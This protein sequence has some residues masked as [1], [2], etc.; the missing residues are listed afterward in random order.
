MSMP[1]HQL[2]SNTTLAEL[3]EGLANAPDIA[4]TGIASDTRDLDSGYLFLACGG[5]NSHGL[6]YAAQAIEAGAIAIAYDSRT[7]NAVPA[8]DV[9]LFAV[10]GLRERLGDIANRF[11]DHPSRTVWVIGVTGTNGKTTVAW[12]L[13]QCLQRLG[14]PSGYAGTLGYGMSDVELNIAEGMTTPDVIEM[15]RRLAA[16]RDAGAKFAVAEVSSHALTQDRIKGVCIDTALF[17][18][19]SRD[20]LDYHGDMQAYAEAKAK[21]FVDAGPTR[22]IVNIDTDFG[23]ELATRCGPDAIA[24]STNLDRAVNGRPHVFVR[25]VVAKQGGSEVTV[26][27]SWGNGTVRVPLP[28][29]FNVA[30]AVMALAFLLTEGIPFDEAGAVV[31]KAE[32]PPGRMQR[33]AVGSGPEVYVDYAHTPNALEVA[34]RALR[35]HARGKLWCVF[36]CGG[37]RDSGKRPLMARVVERL[38]DRIV[39]TTDNPR[40][41]DA[42]DIINAIAGGFSNS[43]RATIIEDRAA[44]IA[45]A[46]SNAAPADV[47]L[48]AG[49]GHENYQF[50]GTRRRDF[51]DYEIAAANLLA[52]PHGEEDDT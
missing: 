26:R 17:T 5:V 31:S 27:S 46:V 25:S 6:D 18:N 24:V 3:L 20:H 40:N 2:T 23:A 35:P 29:D 48:L 42:G 49:K 39:V 36:G 19:L 33:V 22:R 7:A 45:W 43:E 32:A 34:L 13:A 4:I 51:S 14:R 41:E 9:P 28:G 21:L 12:M 10:D 38:A 47:V 44:A 11:F 37:D 50:V 15:H 16:F 1:A 52:R 8:V 30:N